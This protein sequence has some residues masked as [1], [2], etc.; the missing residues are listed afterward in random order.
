MITYPGITIIDGKL[1]RG[2]TLASVIIAL[3]YKRVLH[4]E[5]YAN[6][7][8][9]GIP[10]QIIRCLPDLER[11]QHGLLILDETYEILD[12]RRAQSN[13]NK[14]VN[15]IIQRSRKK[16]FHVIV[17]AQHPRMVDVRLRQLAER[18]ISPDQWTN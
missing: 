9:P 17:I 11:V 2:K 7:D 14:A 12:S 15:T 8:I 13:K 1:G 16:N 18:I 3:Y 4:R 6:F 5:V 10:H